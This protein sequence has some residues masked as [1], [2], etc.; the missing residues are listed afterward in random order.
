MG[1]TQS[2]GGNAEKPMEPAKPCHL[3]HLQHQKETTWGRSRLS[4]VNAN[5]VTPTHMCTRANELEDDKCCH[6]ESQFFS[7]FLLGYLMFNDFLHKSPI[8]F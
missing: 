8:H 3:S 7:G 4:M 5:F 6:R 2:L 1:N